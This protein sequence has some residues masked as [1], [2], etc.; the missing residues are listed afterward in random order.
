MLE[1]RSAEYLS[2]VQVIDGNFDPCI[3]GF[4]EDWKNDGNRELQIRPLHEM[5]GDWYSWGTFRGGTNTPENYILAFQHVHNV[6]KEAGAN[7]KM[8]LCYN[9]ESANK[10]TGSFLQWW[11]GKSS[12]YNRYRGYFYAT[13]H[14]LFVS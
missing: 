4:I 6:F 12:H 5:N 8:Q 7:F 10:D 3:L 14:T 2:L 13:F 11:P 1:L 9:C